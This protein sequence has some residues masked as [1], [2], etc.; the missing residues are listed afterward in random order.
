METVQELDK[1]IFKYFIDTLE[2]TKNQRVYRN[3]DIVLEENDALDK[4]ASISFSV[5]NRFGDVKYLIF[6]KEKILNDI[7]HPAA[8]IF[9]TNPDN[10][11][12]TNKIVLSTYSNYSIELAQKLL[13]KFPNEGT[14]QF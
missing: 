11:V 9:G 12:D 2:G 8:Y 10:T 3:A 1:R 13:A 5:A 4:Y 14:K 7:A 6:L